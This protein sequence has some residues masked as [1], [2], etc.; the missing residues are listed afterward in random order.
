[1]DIRNID[2]IITFKPTNIIL[3]CWV[4]AWVSWSYLALIHVSFDDQFR[5]YRGGNGSCS[6]GCNLREKKTSIFLIARHGYKYFS[7]IL[8]LGDQWVK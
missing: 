7:I 6:V 1:M 5:E 4:N 3:A 2:T 8:L